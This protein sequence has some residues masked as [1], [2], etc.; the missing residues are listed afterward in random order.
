MYDR[1]VVELALYALSE[2]YSTKEVS[3]ICGA[4]RGA[5][6]SWAAGDVPHER[7][8][9]LGGGSRGTRRGEGTRGGTTITQAAAN[10]ESHPARE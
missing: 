1:D 8:K 10:P 3:E 5:V 9:A 4:S 6:A 2:G 7:K